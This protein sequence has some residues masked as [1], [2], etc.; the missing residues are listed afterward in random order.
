ME[1]LKLGIIGVGVMGEAIIGGAIRAGAVESK[2]VYA[3]DVDS[4]KL[5]AFAERYSVHAC[6]NAPELVGQTDVVLAAVKPATFEP[7]LKD[8]AASLSNKALI[9][10]VA[11]W[12]TAKIMKV[13]QKET[14]L[15]CV[16]PNMAAAVG[17]S[18]SVLASNNTLSSSELL[19]VSGLFGTIGETEI[20]DE[21]YFDIVTGLSGSGPAFVMM[22]IEALM[23]AGVY[24]GLPAKIARKLAV[25]TVI[26][27]A[28]TVKISEKHPAELRDAVCT[29]GGTTIE[30]VL[31]LEKSAFV[32][33]VMS[34][35]DKSTKKFR[36][37]VNG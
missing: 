24:N 16:M 27:A 3:F 29:P 15:L 32:G 23:Q 12:N 18:M 13:L 33:T 21:K 22:F 5:Q 1:T 10:I 20:L 11:G 6:K 2:N 17:E 7:L 9:S 36:Q 37:M 26:G 19:F 31:E 34:A 25:Q 8:I 28:R 30:G 4:T 35:V 14:R